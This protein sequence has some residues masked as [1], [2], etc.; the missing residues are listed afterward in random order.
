VKSPSGRVLVDTLVSGLEG[1]EAP[2]VVLEIVGRV[3][4]TET[5]FGVAKLPSSA[6]LSLLSSLSPDTISSSS[7][8]GLL[9][10]RMTGDSGLV[11]VT[12]VASLRPSVHIE[13]VPIVVPNVEPFFLSFH[14]LS[15]M[16]SLV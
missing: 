3:S 2:V 8:G 6:L 10:S 1:V 7:S 4:V 9:S 12:L 16:D 5:N 13:S 15:R 14:R 11:T